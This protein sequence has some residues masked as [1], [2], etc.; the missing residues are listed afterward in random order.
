VLGIIEGQMGSGKTL[1]ATAFAVADKINN[2]MEIIC[3]YHL[4]NIDYQ[5]LTFQ[6]FID[7]MQQS[8]ELSNTTVIIDEA[9]L[10][11]DSRSSQTNLNKLFGYF[12]VQTRKRDVNLYVTV[13]QFRNVD[14]RLRSNASVR[15]I[16]KYNEKTQYCSL[17]LI[18]LKTGIRKFIKIYGPDW[19]EYYDT[20]EIPPT[21]KSMF[22]NVKI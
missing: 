15:G 11:A 14:L 18:N 22:D 19:F 16:C 12:A 20:K 21:R 3:N 8:V 13:Q 4:K 6:N 1:S 10:F 2:G 17:T 7:W 5:Y 9:Y